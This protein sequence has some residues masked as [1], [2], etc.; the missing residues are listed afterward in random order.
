[1][2]AALLAL[3]I[4]GIVY[5]LVDTTLAALAEPTRRRVVE[6]LNDGPARATDIAAHLGMTPAATSRHLRVLRTAGLVE[7]E[8]PDD[9]TR[10]RLY[11]LK[12]DQLAGLRAWL[13]QVQAH[14]TEQ[15]G[16]F[17]EHAERTRGR[18]G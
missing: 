5:D 8:T 9:D 14:W 2:T 15:L 16:A 7:V 3:I 17:K 11:R 12:P 1:L 4:N 6:L 18:H 10:V 13:D